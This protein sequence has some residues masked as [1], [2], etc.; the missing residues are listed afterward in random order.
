MAAILKTP[1]HF[2]FDEILRFLNRS[3]KEC[4]HQ[5]ENDYIRKLISTKNQRLLVDIRQKKE[6]QLNLSFPDSKANAATKKEVKNYSADWLDLNTDLAA[7]YKN[8]QKDKILNP[9]IKQFSGLR[10]IGLPDL[11]E[12]LSWAIIGQQINLNF[13]YSLKQRLVE[14]YGDKM[15]FEN[16]IYYRFP[17]PSTIAK[18]KT[19]DLRPLQF[20]ERKAEYLIGLAKIMAAD[21]ISKEQLSSL[22]F[23]DAH[24]KL[25]AI[26]G[27]GNWTANY[28]LMKCLRHQDAFPIEDAGLHNALKQQLGWDRKP[29]LAEIEKL[30]HPWIGWRA[31]AVFYLWQSLLK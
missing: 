25:V 14:K 27:I 22:S 1:S 12:A 11:F 17:E 16:Q 28:V 3:P 7:F 19:S 15:S 13:A 21:E 20:S 18:I 4:L 31:Y 30:A 29:T 6:G 5:V 10:I 8:V 2:N 26:R 23:E 9:L 24:K